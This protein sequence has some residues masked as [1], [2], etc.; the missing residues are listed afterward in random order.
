M[1][2][3]FSYISKPVNPDEF[4]F[5]VDTNNICFIKLELYKD[6]VISLVNLIYD[7]YLGEEEIGETNIRLT[8]EDNLKHFEWCWKKTLENFRKE[9]IIFEPDGD[10]YDFIKSFVLFNII[11]IIFKLINVIFINQLINNCFIFGT[12]IH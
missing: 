1:E 8:N 9:K 12:N 5:W 2:N 7:T 10:H 6:F 11:Y 4:E 3:F